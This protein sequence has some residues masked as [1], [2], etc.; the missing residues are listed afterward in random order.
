MAP[1]QVTLR[2]DNFI[3]ITLEPSDMRENVTAYAA[4]ISGEPHSHILPFQSANSSQLASAT[5]LYNASYHGL[6]YTISLLTGNASTWSRPD[7]SV[8][9]LT[10]KTA[11]GLMWLDR[12]LFSVVMWTNIVS[13]M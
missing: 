13:S 9:L 3:L 4:K 5:L 7:K 6:C 8:A 1:F 10:S 11:R 12:M 2:D